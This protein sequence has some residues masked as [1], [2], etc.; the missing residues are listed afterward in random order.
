MEKGLPSKNNE[1]KE[2]NEMIKTKL[3]ILKLIKEAEA[4]FAGT[5]KA[6]LDIEDYVAEYLAARGVIA[7]PCKVGDK[8]YF[9]IEDEQFKEKY[10]SAEPITEVGSKG[11]WTSGSY[12]PSDDMTNFEPWE[13]LGKTAF[14][15]YEEA[16]K[17]IESDHND[18]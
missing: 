15:S 17:A 6:L 5:G 8:A 18:H 7:P 11:F 9:I 10:I 13:T 12:I 14:L 4:Q 1:N 3:S 2:V 16:E